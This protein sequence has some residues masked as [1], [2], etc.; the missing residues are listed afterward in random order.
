MRRNIVLILILIINASVFGQSDPNIVLSSFA[1]KNNIIWVQH[2]GTLGYEQD[3]IVNFNK[4]MNQ[5]LK[6]LAL[7]KIL[8]IVGLNNKMYKIPSLDFL[9]NLERL[10]LE[11]SGIKDISAISNLSLRSINL[12]WNSI[13][14]EDLTPILSM[15]SLEFIG[16]NGSLIK[17]IPDFSG[18]PK[19]RSLS[20]AE[21][22]ITSL[23][24]IEVIKEPLVLDISDCPNLADIDALKDVPLERLYISEKD[25]EGKFADWFEENLEYLK[26]K[27]PGFDFRV[28]YWE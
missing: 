24:G 16:L 6:S 10:S 2:S 11:S 3:D 25:L 22:S 20:L 13:T 15:E 9:P 1:K 26:E 12:S 17:S 8:G 7:I 28:G 14:H 18:L 27:N 19:L 4:L 5:P 21:S 23:D